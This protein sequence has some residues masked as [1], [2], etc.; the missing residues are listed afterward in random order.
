MAGDF[1]LNL[2]EGDRG[3]IMQDFYTNF[4]M[5]IAVDQLDAT[6]LIYG[7]SKNYESTCSTRSRQH[8]KTLIN[9]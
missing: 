9:F 7:V 2:S 1:N 8:K 4:A 6:I 5:D 3:R